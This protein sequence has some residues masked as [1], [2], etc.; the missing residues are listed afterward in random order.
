[1]TIPA[2]IA[3]PSRMSKPT[4]IN[5]T[6]KLGTVLVRGMGMHMHNANNKLN[7]PTICD[8]H[9]WVTNPSLGRI[10]HDRRLSHG[11]PCFTILSKA[12]LLNS[13]F[14]KNGGNQGFLAPYNNWKD[15]NSSGV[16]NNK[17]MPGGTGRGN[18]MGRA[19]KNSKTPKPR[20]CRKS[21]NS[22]NDIVLSVISPDIS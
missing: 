8:T 12:V 18:A 5:R 2:I 17:F 4:A 6:A 20:S 3:R 7:K 14:L 21:T 11:S 13:R 1:M 22:P 15:K 19:N 9:P 10:N 16:A